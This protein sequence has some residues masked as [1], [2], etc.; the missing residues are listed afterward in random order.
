MRLAVIIPAAGSSTRFS[1][2]LAVPRSKLDE[3][4]GGRPVLQRT[5]ELFHQD[6]R[7][8]TIVVAGPHDPQA[9]A[10]FKL[11]HG[12]RLGLL[13]VT[14]C[15]GGKTHRYETVAA[16][17]AHVPADATHIAVHDAARP[18][19]PMDLI[20]RVFKAAE[21]FAAVIPAVSVGDTLKRV[22]DFDAGAGERDAVA[23]IL[24]V[25]DPNAGR[26]RRVTATL[27]R[28]GLVAV[29]TPQVFSAELLRRA[30]A[31]KD[32]SST[33]DAGLVERLGET[34][35]VVEGDAR[36]LKVTLPNDVTLARMILGFKD[37]EGRATH[38]RF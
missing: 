20:E 3:D 35:V 2:G 10:E 32:L 16:A 19:T 24:G 28:A 4:L 21:R 9:F 11:R 14:L 8:S 29:Q 1:Q 36:N 34:V 23:D 12:D 27:E 17:L 5:V 38:K 25:A 18:C 31:Q 7:V 30:Y 13:G 33:D 6:E 26:Q 22:E 15:P 37:P